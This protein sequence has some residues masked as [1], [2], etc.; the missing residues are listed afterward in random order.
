MINYTKRILSNG[1]TVLVHED[2]NTSLIAVN[3]LYNV[4]SKDENPEKTGFAHLFEH[5]MFEGS[6]HIASF[7]RVLEEA[8]G[9][10]NAF[11]NNDFTNYY[12]NIPKENIET[13]LWL[14]SDRM[15]NLAFSEERLENQKKVVIEEY[16]QRYLNQ[17]YGDAW[18]L[19]RPLA[20]TIHPYRWPTIGKEINH[21]KHCTLDEVKKFF[22]EYYI[23]AN[24]SLCMS[25]NIRAE[26]AFSLAEKWF[27][28]IPDKKKKQRL[29]PV[30]PP[31]TAQRH[32][33]VYRSVPSEAI[34]IAFHMCS[35]TN[36]M[37]YA[38]DLLSD[39]LSAG[40]SSRLY[41]SLVKEKQLFSQIDAFI[42]NDIDEG[43]FIITAKLMPD[44][45]MKTAENAIWEEIQKIQKNGPTHKELEKVKNR[46]ECNFILANTNVQN[47]AMNLAYYE[48]LGDA[49]LINKEPENI[50]RVTTDDIKHVA[51]SILTENNSS[52]L[53]Y[54]KK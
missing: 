29:L 42:T 26:Q 44:I 43:L 47:K 3:V 49:G 22:Q 45:S 9:E 33:S 46:A 23:P 7:D 35:R 30:E 40:Q 5:L 19:L 27:S 38:T 18:L 28:D 54:F 32:K 15:L 17:P 53:Y 52:T 39:I 24:A 16:K 13:A 36:A 51:A 50:Q 12:L 25:G 4:G 31:Q 41:I 2:C 10:N 6:V 37:F 21:I 34:Y 1:L 20:Y 14:E 8:G 48:L 11:T